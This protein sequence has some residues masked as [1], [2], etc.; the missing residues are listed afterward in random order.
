MYQISVIRA[1]PQLVEFQIS[2]SNQTLTLEIDEL[3]KLGY[4]K[5]ELRSKS[6][7]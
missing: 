7:R 2:E 1:R 5:Q 3:V 4:F 6:T